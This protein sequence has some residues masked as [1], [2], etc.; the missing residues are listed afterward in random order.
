MGPQGPFRPLRAF[1]ALKGRVS[2]Y[3]GQVLQNFVG[4][5]G[6][7]GVVIRMFEGLIYKLGQCF[8]G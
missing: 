5:E 4:T 1:K 3:I 7:R 8:L 2:P 6:L